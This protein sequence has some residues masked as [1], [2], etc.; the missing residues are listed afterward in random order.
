MLALARNAERA[1][2]IEHCQNRIMTIE[3]AA[4][5]ELVITTTDIH[6]PRLI[7]E[8]IRRAFHGDLRIHYDEMNYFVR[9]EWRG[10]G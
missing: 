10:D 6:L 2:R 8:T 1:E 3:E 9:A 5:D 4:H 7:G